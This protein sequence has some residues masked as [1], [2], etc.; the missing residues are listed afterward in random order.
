VAGVAVLRR[1]AP[2]NDAVGAARHTLLVAAATT[3]RSRLRSSQ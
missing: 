1:F 2:R 3:L